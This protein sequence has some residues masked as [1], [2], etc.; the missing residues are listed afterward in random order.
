MVNEPD[1]PGDNVRELG[2]GS[3]N[4]NANGNDTCTVAVVTADGTPSELSVKVIVW[5]PSELLG[6]LTK[7]D[8]GVFAVIATL[9]GAMVKTDFPLGA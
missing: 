5:S 7:N 4:D 1:P 9:A 3:P 8:C 2:D 6:A